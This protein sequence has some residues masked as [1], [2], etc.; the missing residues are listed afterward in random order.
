MLKE[1]DLENLAELARIR[2]TK[3]EGKKL[4]G[5]LEKILAYVKELD[6]VPTDGIP[7][8]AGGTTLVNGTRPDEGGERLAGDAAREAFP[9][10]NKSFL[11]VPPVFSAEG[12]SA[13]GGE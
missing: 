1:K 3:A 5:D 4:L 11:K 10:S 6:E 13:T 12:G 7:P 8:M 9:E 2:L